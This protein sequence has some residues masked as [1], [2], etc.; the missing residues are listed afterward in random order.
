MQNFKLPYLSRAIS[1][2]WQR[3]HISLST[4]FRDYLSQPACGMAVDYSREF[5]DRHE[6][7]FDAVHLNPKGQPLVSQRL[8]Q[9]LAPWLRTGQ[10]SMADAGARTA[11]SQS[12]ETTA[13]HDV[14]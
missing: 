14:P 5:Q 9:D 8:G 1:E 4:W 12:R 11:K 6:L 2:F 7:F 10:V 3:W 13:P